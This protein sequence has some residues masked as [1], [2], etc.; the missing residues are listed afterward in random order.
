MRNKKFCFFNN[1][2]KFLFDP[3]V[4]YDGKTSLE[5]HWELVK[6]RASKAVFILDNKGN[7]MDQ[8]LFEIHLKRA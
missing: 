5:I 6:E 4:R 2:S 7:E 3:F 8:A 1:G